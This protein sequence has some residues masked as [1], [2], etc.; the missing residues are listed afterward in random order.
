M[1]ICYWAYLALSATSAWGV[2]KAWG[3]KGGMEENFITWLRRDEIIRENSIQL[4]WRR[5]KWAGL[6]TLI[7]LTRPVPVLSGT[8]RSPFPAL[9]MVKQSVTL[10]QGICTTSLPVFKKNTIP[11]AWQI[12]V[13]YWSRPTA[14]EQHGNCPLLNKQCVLLEPSL[15]F[16]FYTDKTTNSCFG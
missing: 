3:Y 6:M 14:W 5:D 11:E 9:S 12:G 7:W 8:G 16:D 1:E 10:K 13:G 15:R 4:R 2:G